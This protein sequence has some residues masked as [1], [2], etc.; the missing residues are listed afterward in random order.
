MRHLD[1]KNVLLR[2]C[3]DRQAEYRVRLTVLACV[4]CWA[5]IAVLLFAAGNW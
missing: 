2:R 3:T 1:D 4:V 5:L